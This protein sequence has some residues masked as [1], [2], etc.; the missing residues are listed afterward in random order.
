[1]V[2]L[3]TNP[4]FVP[5]LPYYISGETGKKND[6]KRKIMVVTNE[7]TNGERVFYGKVLQVRKMKASKKILND[8]VSKRKKKLF[9][10]IYS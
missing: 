9:L 5:I 2:P 3:Q 8:R 7:N 6:L 1:M 4:D 10:F